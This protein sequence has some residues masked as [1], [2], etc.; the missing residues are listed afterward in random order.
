MDEFTKK[1]VEVNENES[2]WQIEMKPIPYSQTFLYGGELIQ[3]SSQGEQTTSHY[4][5]TTNFLILCRGEARSLFRR[6]EI[7]WKKLHPISTKV[8]RKLYGFK[9]SSQL[10]EENFYT[11]TQEEQKIWLGYLNKL[12][13]LPNLEADYDILEELGRGSFS[14]VM[15]GRDKVTSEC[16]ALKCVKKQSKGIEGC[17]KEVTLMRRLIHESV[18]QLLKVYDWEIYVVIVLEY[19]PGGSMFDCIQLNKRLTEEQAKVLTSKL[20]RGIDYCHQNRSVHRDL[21]LENILLVNRDNFETIKIAD[22]GLAADQE[23]ES[24]RKRCGSAGYVAPEIILGRPYNEKVDIF[25]AGV[26]LYMCLS[27]TA[28]FSGANDSEMLKSN[29]TCRI[30]TDSIYWAHISDNAKDLVKSMMRKESFQRLSAKEALEHKW[31]KKEARATPPL[32]ELVESS[33]QPS[34]KLTSKVLIESISRRIEET[35]CSY[36]NTVVGR[37]DSQTNSPCP[38]SPTSP[39]TPNVDASR[40]RK[41]AQLVLSGQNTPTNVRENRRPSMRQGFSDY[42]KLAIES[43][44]NSAQK[45]KKSLRQPKGVQTNYLE[46]RRR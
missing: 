30:D 29:A 7:N 21:K 24:L 23:I 31:F 38:G 46:V 27:G 4:M 44:E 1:D 28:P 22:F 37:R 42:A 13:V 35:K 8:P 43:P 19:V 41:F 12:C 33:I 20:L 45:V 10:C 18:I 11:E 15:K 3:L 26:I 6:S 36:L 34:P 39:I 40:L 9:L 32:I 17:M 25:S 14:V 2:F 5:I 16:V